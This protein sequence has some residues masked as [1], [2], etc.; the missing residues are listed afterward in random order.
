VVVDQKKLVPFLSS[1][2]CDL[3]LIVELSKTAQEQLTASKP[4]EY[5]LTASRASYCYPAII[6][7]ETAQPF[8]VTLFHV[9]YSN[10]HQCL[11]HFPES[12]MQY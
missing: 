12:C 9:D 6:A 1:D 10:Y 11:D 3:P 8:W 4:N 5:A 2:G 7:I